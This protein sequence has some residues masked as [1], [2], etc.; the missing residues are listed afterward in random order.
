MPRLL[1]ST[2][3]LPGIGAI[4]FDE[5]HE[6]SLNLDFGLAL[7]RH[8]QRTCRPDLF[9]L[10]MSATLEAAPLSHY[11]DSCPALT[12]SGR[13]FPVETTF[14]RQKIGLYDAIAGAVR[15]ILLGNQPG[16]ILVF[17]PGATEI[18]RC[19]QF[20]L[21]ASWPESLEFL[22]LYG[23]MP[24]VEQRQVM[25][26][27][28]R[29]KIILATNIVETSLTIPGVRQVIDSGL[30]RIM[31]HDPVRGINI[32]ETCPIAR[33]SA[34]QRAGR[35]GREGP[36]RCYRLWS[37]LEQNA[38]PARTSA[39][40][41][42]LD[43]AEILLSVKAFG[44]ADSGAFPWFERPPEKHLRAAE[45]LL[46]NLGLLRSDN[47]GISDLGRQILRYPAHP[48]CALLLHL[49]QEQGCAREA[50]YT[51]AMLSE[52]PLITAASSNRAT[53]TQLRQERRQLPPSDFLA[54]LELLQ[55]ARRAHFEP[56]ACQRLGIH[57]GAARDICRAAE[58]YLAQ[59]PRT[60]AASSDQERFLRCLL[61]V[62]PDRLARRCDQ[63]TLRCDLQYGRRAELSRT[64]LAR[65]AQLLLAGEIRE[66]PADGIQAV[67]L[68]LSLA[69]GIEEEWLWEF[70]PEDFSEKDEIF[71]DQRNQQVL[72]RR[73]LSCRQ[74]VL[75]E[76]VRNDPPPEA[77]AALLAQQIADHSLHL[78]GWNREVENWIARVRFLAEHFPEQSLP[79]YDEPERR[80]ILFWLCQ[81]EYTYRAIRNKECLPWVKQLLTSAQSNFVERMAPTHLPLPRGR[82]LRL[83]Y[84]PGQPPKGRA[85][86]QDLFDCLDPPCVAAGRIP[87]L[88]DILAPNMRTVQITDDLPRFWSVHY[89][90]LKSALARR[91]PKHEWR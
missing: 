38:K 67:K 41:E 53:L 21:R 58:H 73:S 49:G 4:V 89:P 7:A 1:L 48:R 62:F 88:L 15:E 17:L 37:Q 56:A 64:S 40:I 50:A 76:S 45:E 59:L 69:S 43:L 86:I 87:V 31:R 36:G 27:C 70:F 83:E 26:P 5:F 30:A 10:V 2:P 20:L 52:R 35:A 63:G 34:E 60:A 78:Q 23:E 82:R 32:L 19:Q 42:R 72:R 18:R 74:L 51:A 46:Q 84:T 79:A 71:W 55:Q 14:C 54:A 33:D 90:A 80:K 9:L 6:R 29:R 3:E 65:E 61:R 81:G 11:L 57:S 13:Q 16:D 44:F 66:V 91:Y 39:E 22:P 24:P 28:D 75:E 8:C 12:A 68:E 25:Q 77:A 85:R 47:G